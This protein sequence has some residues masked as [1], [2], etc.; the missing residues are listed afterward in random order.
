MLSNVVVPLVACVAALLLTPLTTRLAHLKGWVD[1]PGLRK[2][3]SL[4]VAYLGGAAVMGAL[5]VALASTFWV[6]SATSFIDAFDRRIGAIILGG[7]LMFSVGI[8][9]DVKDIKATK[10]LLAQL[11]CLLYTSPSPRDRTRSRMPS[12]A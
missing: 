12:S 1:R 10:K 5:L 9:D 7:L 4:P 11:A 6:P 8:V 2:V 3:H